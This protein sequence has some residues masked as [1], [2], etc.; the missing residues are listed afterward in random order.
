MTENEIKKDEKQNSERAYTKEEVQKI[1]M[2]QAQA[3][4]SQGL[5]L[6]NSNGEGVFTNFKDEVICMFFLGQQGILSG[7]EIRKSINAFKK[8]LNLDEISVD[9]WAKRSKPPEVKKK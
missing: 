6:P 9:D 5:P 8:E 1:L 2:Q 7:E 3:Q 4:K